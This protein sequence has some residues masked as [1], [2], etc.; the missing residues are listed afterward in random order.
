MSALP[1]EVNLDPRGVSAWNL[2]LVAEDAALKNLEAYTFV[3]P[4]KYQNEVVGVRVLGFFLLDFYKHSNF[5]Q[6][7]LIQ[8]NHLVGEILSCFVGSD[9]PIFKAVF[10]LGVSYRNHL[11][12]VCE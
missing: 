3:K 8:Y 4:A 7:N 12:R 2:L 9:E 10:E 5:H 6:I 1:K 11:R